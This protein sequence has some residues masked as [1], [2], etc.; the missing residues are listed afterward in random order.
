MSE[1]KR[2][3]KTRMRSAREEGKERRE[4]RLTEE[5]VLP[6]ALIDEVLVRQSEDLHDARELLLFV[7]S[8]E[9]GESGVKLGED[10]TETPHVDGPVASRT[11]RKAAQLFSFVFFDEKKTEKWSLTY[12]S[13]HRG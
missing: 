10:A 9:D 1:W 13:S 8:W 12:G 2:K 7:L 5:E 6:R 4:G 3:R 11:K